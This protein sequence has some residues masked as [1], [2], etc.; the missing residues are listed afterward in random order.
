MERVL[1]SLDGAE[2]IG[3]AAA[4]LVGLV[5]CFLGYRLLRIVV[6]ICGF[7][8]GAALGYL[9]AGLLGGSEQV[10]WIAALVGGLTGA[11]LGAAVFRFGVFLVGAAA[12]AVVG[13]MIGSQLTGDAAVA[14]IPVAA[15]L[16]GILAVASRR[17]VIIFATASSG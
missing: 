4:V 14:A 8:V 2:T 11:A 15:V 16:V 10:T 9:L 1:S 7:A 17:I 5:V 3:A 6:A 13:G 12:G